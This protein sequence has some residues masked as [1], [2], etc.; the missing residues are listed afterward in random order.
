MD[1]PPVPN[2]DACMA[3]STLQSEHSQIARSRGRTLNRRAPAA[4]I[5]HS[6]RRSYPG[7]VVENVANEPTAVKPGV[8]CIAAVPIGCPH[9]PHRMNSYP[10]SP[11]GCRGIVRSVLR[12]IALRH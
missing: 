6:A 3:G 10:L 4:D 12:A 5:D 7:S 9:K 1:K 8:R 11:G 2:V